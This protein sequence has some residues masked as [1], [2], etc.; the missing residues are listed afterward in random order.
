M[1]SQGNDTADHY[2]HVHATMKAGSPADYALPTGLKMPAG[3]TNGMDGQ[4]I[5]GGIQGGRHR[6]G[7]QREAQPGGEQRSRAC[8]QRRAR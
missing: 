4:S 1:G 7:G 5:G 6:H 3:L 8:S 2:D